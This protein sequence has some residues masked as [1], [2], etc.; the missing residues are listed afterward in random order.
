VGIANEQTGVYPV[1][2]PGGWS[3]IGRTPVQMIGESTDQPFL[4]SPGDRVQFFSID[5]A[6]FNRQ[7]GQG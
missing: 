5:V 7:M 6:E 3:I 4:V 2:S 1:D